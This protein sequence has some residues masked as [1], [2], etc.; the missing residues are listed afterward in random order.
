MKKMY[1]V[2]DICISRNLLSMGKLSGNLL[3]EILSK[4]DPETTLLDIGY[5]IQ[6]NCILLSVT[7]PKYGECDG[8]AYVKPTIDVTIIMQKDG[9]PPIITVDELMHFD[10]KGHVKIKTDSN[11]KEKQHPA[12]ETKCDCGAEKS[13]WNVHS[14]WCSKK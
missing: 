3:G 8:G 11:I 4:L 13:G 1:K 6:R 10:R 5:D 7:N 14:D 12:T 2:K 9:L